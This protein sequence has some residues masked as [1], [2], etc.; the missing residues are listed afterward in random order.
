MVKLGFKFLFIALSIA[1]LIGC[2]GDGDNP[3]KDGDSSVKKSYIGSADPGD[4][5]KFKVNGNQLEFNLTGAVFGPVNGLMTLTDITGKGVFFEGSYGGEHV[6]VA[7]TD[8]LGIAIVPTDDIGGQTVVMGLQFTEDS[9]N[10]SDI[11]NKSYI[12]AEM[13]KIGDTRYAEGHIVRVEDNHTVTIHHANGDEP[14]SGCWKL[15]GDHIVV[16][17]DLESDLCGEGYFSLNDTNADVRV[18]IRPPSN[19]GRAGFIADSVAGDFVGIGLEQKAIQ[20]VEMTGAYDIYIH[21]FIYSGAMPFYKI[22]VDNNGST[23]SY[24]VYK[25]A[26]DFEGSGTI[27]INRIC[28]GT[29]DGLEL[30]NHGS[31]G[32]ICIDPGT[33]FEHIGFID[34]DDGYFMA[35]RAD[36]AQMIFGSKYKEP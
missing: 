13:G 23:A 25:N 26:G 24:R 2:G 30:P 34:K 1:V 14:D 15:A 35:V 12:Y 31:D 21:S 4:F 17:I 29:A 18:I 8:N 33:P 36:G 16:K 19:S 20:M 27:I 3:P 28:N 10:E 6:A 22:V 7:L 11:S 32:I 5:A 9:I